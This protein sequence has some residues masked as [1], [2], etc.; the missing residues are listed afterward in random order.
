MTMS[1][2]LDNLIRDWTRIGAGFGA[3][4]AERTPDLERL[5]LDTARQA[6]EMARLFIMAA[7]WLRTYGELVARHRLRRLVRDELE[8]ASRPALGLLLSIAQEGIRPPVFQTIVRDLPS[9]EP[10]G[11]LFAVE[12]ESARRIQRARRRASP[13][14]VRWGLWCEPLELKP[15]ALRPP[16]WVMLQNPEFVLR[17]DFRG[18]LRASVLASLLYDPAARESELELAR[19]AGGSRAQ[20]RSALDNLELSGR[21]RRDRAS[22]PRRT[23]IEVIRAA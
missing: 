9:A 10:A 8:H 14:S 12:R 5:L 15:D 7:T 20:V 16:A 6:P 18:D 2:P 21:V 11:P 13:L 4:P 22:D 1:K 19:R 3:R 23:R 17:A